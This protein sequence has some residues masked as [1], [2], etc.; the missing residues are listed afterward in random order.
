MNA[1]FLISKGNIKGFGRLL[2]RIKVPMKNA[3]LH[4]Q[5]KLKLNHANLTCLRTYCILNK[6]VTFLY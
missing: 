3:H 2:L 1:V 4:E 6:K 5:G